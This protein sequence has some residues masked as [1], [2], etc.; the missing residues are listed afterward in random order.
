MSTAERFRNDL[1]DQPQL[2][3]LG[4]GQ[5]QRFRRFRCVATV[6]PENCGT[7]FRTDDRIVGVLQH[8]DTIS[9]PYS[10]SSAGTT[11]TDHCGNYGCAQKHHFTQIHCNRFRDMSFFGS[12]SRVSPRRVNQRDHRKAKPFPKPHDTERL[13]V[14]FRVCAPEIA[15]NILLRIPTL[16]MRDNDT[17]VITNCGEPARHSLVVSKKPIA[18]QL[19]EIRKS[20]VQVIKRERPRSMPRNLHFLPGRKPI[21]NFAFGLF[22]LLLHRSHFALEIKR[23]QLRMLPQLVQL[24]LEFD[25]WLLKFQRV[26]LHLTITG[27]S[28]VTKAKSSSISVGPSMIPALGF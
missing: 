3:E 25:D 6:F 1:V 4:S 8:Q 18:V 17:T 19:E 21:V 16:L 23:M 24:F 26:N 11:F 15:S 22:N 9:D 2:L 28:F 13:P 27:V 12:D 7:T 10:Q 5:L 20:R 14:S